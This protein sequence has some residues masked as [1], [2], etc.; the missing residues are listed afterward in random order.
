MPAL[1]PVPKCVRIALQG[2]IDGSKPFVNLFHLGYSVGGTLTAAEVLQLATDISAA[3]G[4]SLAPG[5]SDTVQLVD[6]VA[7]ALDSSTAPT[8]TFPSGFVGGQSTQPTAGGTALVVQRKIA[9]RY[10]GG[11]SRVYLPGIPAATLADTEDHWDPTLLAAFTGQWE[12]IEGAGA[13]Y[14][15]TAGRTDATPVSVSYYEFFTNVLYPSGRYHARPTLR[16][17]PLVDKVVSFNGNPRPCS[18]RRRQQP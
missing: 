1:P 10:R 8:V 6:V 14:L 9:R 15:V 7:T 2:L 5:L 13:T 11:H 18:Q 17:T 16:V 3:W 12:S 4:S